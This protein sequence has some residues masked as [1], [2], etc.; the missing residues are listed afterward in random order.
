MQASVS[1]CGGLSK[2]LN[3]GEFVVKVL[4]VTARLGRAGQG[5]QMEHIPMGV[6]PSLGGH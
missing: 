6:W 5:S 3:E 4:T 2:T 1:V